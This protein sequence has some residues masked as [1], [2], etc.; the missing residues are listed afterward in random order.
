MGKKFSIS[1]KKKGALIAIVGLV[2]VGAGI[3]ITYAFNSSRAVI[4]N[5]FKPSVYRTTAT[6]VFTAPTNWQPCETVPKTITVTNESTSIPVAARIK[7]EESWLDQDGRYQ[8]LVKY[9]TDMTVAI[10]NFAEN[11]GWTLKDGYYEYNTDLAPGATTAPLITGVTLNCDTNFDSSANS[12]SSSIWYYK[13]YHLKATV[14]TVQADAR[15]EWSSLYNAVASK[16]NEPMDIDFTRYA[17]EP[18][19]YSTQF[20]GKNGW[21]VNKYTENGKDVY[22]FR[23]DEIPDNYVIWANYCW[24]IVRTTATGGVKMIYDGPQA[25]IS[26]QCNAGVNADGIAVDGQTWHPFNKKVINE[27]SP[28]D[29]GYMYGDRVYYKYTYDVDSTYIFSNNVSRSGDTYTLDTSAGQ[30]ITG[31][32]SDKRAEAAT[33]YHYFCSNGAASCSSDE[34]GYLYNFRSTYAIYYLAI[35]GYDD[36]EAVKTAMFANEHDSNAKTVIESWFENENLD[37]H[38]E[39]TRNYEN[40]LEDAVFCNDR[41]LYSGSLKGKDEDASEMSLIYFGSHGRNNI[42]NADNNYEPSLD[43]SNPRDAFQVSNENAKLKHKVGLITDDELTLAGMNSSS[44]YLYFGYASTTMT[45][46]Y[47]H[48]ASNYCWDSNHGN[49]CLTIDRIKIRPMVSLKA[50]TRF[51]S[52]SGAST[53]PYI[54]P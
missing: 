53:D 52:G 22:Y 50:G 37:G 6:D 47:F 48:D 32:W 7:L 18:R 27:V 34:I 39:G 29:V 15:D 46:H 23:G 17:E 2:A 9:G 20:T 24:K 11:S 5:E 51:T 44:A 25:P 13:T 12:D 42:R 21:G 41:S 30:S 33:R 54:I 36:I 1:I 45:P 19:Y 35:G 14:Q 43:C 31:T 28:A 3:G 40:D 38:I 8:P 49:S 26:G 16:V 10:V 4:G